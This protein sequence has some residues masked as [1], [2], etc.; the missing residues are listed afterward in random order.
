LD[1]TLQELI[2]PVRFLRDMEE[3]DGVSQRREILAEMRDR[4]RGEPRANRAGKL[5]IVDATRK[6]DLALKVPVQEH[7]L[8]VRAIAS[9]NVERARDLVARHIRDI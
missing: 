8:I 3:Y 7:E 1:A 9:Q 2:Q 5:Q 6:A 4:G